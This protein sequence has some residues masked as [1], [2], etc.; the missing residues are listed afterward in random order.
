VRLSASIAALALLNVGQKIAVDGVT[1]VAG[2]NGS[3]TI[4][5]L[6]AG[7]SPVR[8]DIDLAGSVFSGAYT[9][10]GTIS[11]RLVPGTDG[12]TWLAVPPGV[13]YEVATPYVEADLFDL[14]FV[15][16]ADVLT[17]VHPNYAPRELRRQG[18]SSWTLGGIGFGTAAISP[19]SPSLSTSG[20]GGGVPVDQSYV[21]TS[22]LANGEESLPSAV[23]TISYD[24]SP[25]GNRI[26]AVTAQAPEHVGAVKFNIYKRRGTFGYIGSL[27]VGYASF[28]DDNIL[29]DPSKTPPLANNP[30]A[31]DWPRAV[32]YY[33]QRRA[34][35]GTVNL[36]QNLFFTRSSTENNMNASSPS[37]DDDAIIARVVAREA[38][39]IRHLV[40]LGD[41]LALTSGGV[42]RVA[43]SDSGPLSPSSISIK[44]QSYVGASNAQPVVT[45]TAVI[46]VAD[47]GSHM[48]EVS[49]K[50]ETQLYQSDDIS[51]L[52]PHLFDF[53]SVVQLAYTRAPLQAVWAVRNDGV[54]LGLTYTPEHE[55]KAWH[56]HETAGAFESVCAVA[57]GSEDGVYVIVRRTINGGTVR[58]VERKH[59]RQFVDLAD[60]FFVDAGATYSGAPA[61]VIL[62]L[63]HLEGEEVAILADGGVEPRQTV[64]GGQITLESPASKV[65]VGLAYNCDLQTLPFA[66]EALQAFGQGTVKNVNE[67][68]LRVLQSSGVKAGPSFDKL[69]EYRQ[70]SSEPYGSAP[71]PVTGMIGFKLAPQW[72]EDGAVCVRQAD[73]LP[74]TILSMSLEAEVGG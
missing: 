14:H 70:R 27:P 17:I 33:E 25:S 48:Q 64:V 21:Y 67:V 52:A 8:T 35:G 51:V 43:S 59:T 13:P 72:Q 22:E 34:F 54:L 7:L 42:W 69:T 9:G 29:P 38:N 36:P 23:A 37:Q 16:S 61:T 26:T 3:W 47:R 55:V 40:P 71:A 53:K 68:K 28:T 74:L 15:Q 20:P 2:A 60:A 5:R 45:A 46:Y 65:H 73:P 49:Y 62:G 18:P 19:F 6:G 39:T 63:G 30:F 58:Y 32:S 44:P 10:G 41:L 66:S 1:G 50:W 11:N 12:A 31:A 4:E 56:Q 24:L 57:E